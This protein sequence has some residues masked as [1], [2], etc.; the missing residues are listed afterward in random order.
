MLSLTSIVLLAVFQDV[1]SFKIKNYTIL[2]GIIIG[3]L[4]NLFELGVLGIY[5]Y[6]IGMIIPIIVLFPLFMIKALGAGDIKLLSVVGCFLGPSDIIKI[7]IISFFSGG[8][9]SILYIIRSKSLF[10][11]YRH[12]K[13]YISQVIK[14]YKSKKTANKIDP[15]N[16][17]II[18]YYQKERD[19]RS[20]VIHFSVA[21]LMA[22]VFII[23]LNFKEI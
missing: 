12:F 11:R 16:I 9:L 14:E 1:K 15:N 22:L 5:P 2:I 4:F 20:G 10:K 23:L 3:T 21:I 8:V 6:I 19:G 7:I 13:S 18:P 17:R